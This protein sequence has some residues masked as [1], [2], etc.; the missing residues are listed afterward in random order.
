MAPG[1]HNFCMPLIL[2][3]RVR[4]EWLAGVLSGW[5]SNWLGGVLAG[6]LVGWLSG[7][8]AVWWAGWKVGGWVGWQV[9]GLL[10]VWCDLAG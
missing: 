1:I 8:L 7:L 6:W 10:A 9:G 5:C 4:A 3:T 2:T